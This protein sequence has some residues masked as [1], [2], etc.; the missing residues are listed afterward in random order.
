[1]QDLSSN[2]WLQWA[3]ELEDEVDCDVAAGLDLGQNLAKYLAKTQAHISYEK[4][5]AILQ[6]ELGNILSQEEI[7]EIVQKTENDIL[8][9]LQQKFQHSNV[10]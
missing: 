7:E 1:M 10:A 4:L 9:C 8:D 6:E 5:I 2:S 3:V